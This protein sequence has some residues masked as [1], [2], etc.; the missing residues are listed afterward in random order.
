MTK[1]GSVHIKTTFERN[2]KLD[3]DHSLRRPDIAVCIRF[4]SKYIPV[5]FGEVVSQKITEDSFQQ[6][7]YFQLSCLRPY[8]INNN[9]DVTKLLG[10]VID[11]SSFWIY[12][13]KINGWYADN[14]MCID[15]AMVYFFGHTDVPEKI[16]KVL[17]LL[18][19]RLTNG[20]FSIN[21]S[22][23]QSFMNFYFPTIFFKI[24]VPKS[25]SMNFCNCLKCDDYSEALSI[26]QKPSKCF[27]VLFQRL[28]HSE[29]SISCFIKASLPYVSG[30]RCYS[31]KFASILNSFQQRS[32]SVNPYNSE[33]NL[34]AARGSAS[35][36]LQIVSLS[37]SSLSQADQRESSFT[38]QT[39]MEYLYYGLIASDS[40]RIVVTIS[41]CCQ[42]FALD[43]IEFFELWKKQ[44]NIGDLFSMMFIV[45]L[46]KLSNSICSIGIFVNPT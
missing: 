29:P 28:T 13:I 37:T 33:D 16:A 36:V 12:D 9:P 14:L 21:S 10:F 34:Q 5:A 40:D 4:E 1:S 32:N 18:H 27:K 11:S 43:K 41:R 2:L 8:I 38:F 3:F 35:S 24:T 7:C 30:G 45:L 39:L 17:T 42:G 19:S 22:Y 31:S 6:L 15:N 46:C 44:K 23:L 25:I 26:I 20:L